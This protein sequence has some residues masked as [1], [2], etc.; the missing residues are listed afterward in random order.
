MKKFFLQD[1]SLNYKPMREC[2]N[3]PHRH[4][5]LLMADNVTPNVLERYEVRYGW[6]RSSKKYPTLDIARQAI[7]VFCDYGY[8]FKRRYKSVTMKEYFELSMRYPMKWIGDKCYINNHLYAEV[9]Q[10]F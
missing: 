7:K 2:N 3:C 10:L 1:V 5:S 4:N 6:C 9:V 8:I